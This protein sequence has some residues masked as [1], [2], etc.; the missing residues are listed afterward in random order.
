MSYSLAAA[1][2]AT[3]LNKTTILRAIKSGRI[4]G[5]KDD[6][7]QWFVE[8]IELHRVFEPVAS[9]AAVNGAAHRDATP[10]AAA[11]ADAHRRA[12]LAVE[13]AMLREQLGDARHERDAWRDQ[14]Q[15]LAIADQ[16]ERRPWWKRLAG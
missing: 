11:I 10:D 2:A 16:R 7:G 8:P 15:R 9:A 5:T 12:A 3:G 4:S 14:A 6:K 1:A 13:V